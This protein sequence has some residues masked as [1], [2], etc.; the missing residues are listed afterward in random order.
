[1]T[2]RQFKV[3]REKLYK[4]VG[5]VG[6]LAENEKSQYD[7]GHL[8]EAYA[9]GSDML[10]AIDSLGITLGF[11]DPETNDLIDRRFKLERGDRLNR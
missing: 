11:L 5:E 2:R 10:D 7:H 4:A 1:M 3:L 8:A 6:T 9:R